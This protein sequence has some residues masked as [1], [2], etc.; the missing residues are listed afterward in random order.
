MKQRYA[1]QALVW[2]NGKYLM[3]VGLPFL[4][5]KPGKHMKYPNSARLLS[6]GVFGNP[7]QSISFSHDCHTPAHKTKCLRLRAE[8]IRQ[9]EQA[10]KSLA[11]E[12]KLRFA[13][14]CAR[15]VT[16]DHG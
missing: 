7:L 11:Q 13:L 5:E 12:Q 2:G 8:T 4:S 1:S 3:F 9:D 6:L 14:K 16:F 10:K 15:M